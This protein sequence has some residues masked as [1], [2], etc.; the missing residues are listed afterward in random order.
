MKD[1]RADAFT[2]LLVLH[3]RRSKKL[4]RQLAAQ[5]QAHAALLDEAKARQQEIDRHASLEA[6][7]EAR[8]DKMMRGE[9]GAVKLGELNALFQYREIM[10]DRRRVLEEAYA[11]IEARVLKQEKEVHDTQ[12]CIAKNDAQIEAYQKQLD[13]MHRRLSVQRDDAMDEEAEEAL[14]AGRRLKNVKNRAR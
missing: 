9:A 11:Q 12:C 3:Q 5:R 8:I 1:R 7:H 13:K 2:V 10:H 14:S 6:E 4:E